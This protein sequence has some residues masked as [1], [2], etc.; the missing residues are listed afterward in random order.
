MS[1]WFNRLDALVIGPG[2]GKTKTE[3]LEGVGC[4]L[5]SGSIEFNLC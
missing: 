1:K 3:C 4:G 2:L 5:R